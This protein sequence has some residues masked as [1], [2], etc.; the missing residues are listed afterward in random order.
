MPQEKYKQI[1]ALT[2]DPSRPSSEYYIRCVETNKILT[3]A[4]GAFRVFDFH[5]GKAF[6]QSDEKSGR[7]NKSFLSNIFQMPKTVYVLGSGEKAHEAFNRIPK[8]AYVI[9]CNK[10]VLIPR[11]IREAKFNVSVWVVADADAVKKDWFGIA[12]R[13][14][15]G[16][17]IFSDFAAQATDS[18]TSGTAEYLMFP[19]SEPCRKP[20]W[21]PDEKGLRIGGTVGLTAVE[22]AV[23]CGARKIYLCGFDMSGDTY[24]DGSENIDDRHGEVWPTTKGFDAAI[25]YFQRQ[26]IKIYTLSETKLETPEFVHDETPEIKM[27][28][29]GNLSTP[30]IAYLCM[31][32][33]PIDRMNAIIDCIHQDYP[34]ELKTLYILRQRT[35]EGEF[36]RKINHNMPIRI[37]EI[38][39]EGKWPELW[40][41]KLMAFCE[42]VEEDVTVWW[43]EVG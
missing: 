4:T 23:R 3:D 10:A 24:F 17:R 28:A 19:L 37:R 8:D 30:S 35:K 40:L 26:G 6:L 9:A 27:P 41:L 36:P 11:L 22:T 21:E 29:F 5:T 31:S 13:T 12:D 20:K 16:L 14:F 33:D 32:F 18:Y 25:K 1:K 7:A 42:A 43:D 2:I 38:D 15:Q 34:N 39:V